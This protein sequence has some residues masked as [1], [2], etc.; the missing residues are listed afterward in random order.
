LLTRNSA[1]GNEEPCLAIRIAY[2]YFYGLFSAESF[3]EVILT[4]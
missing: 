1:S 4:G 2:T 3:F